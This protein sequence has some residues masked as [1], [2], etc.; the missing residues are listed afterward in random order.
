MPDDDPLPPVFIPMDLDTGT[1]EAER[2]GEF[3]AD[4]V[5][6]EN[7]EAQTRRV[8][9]TLT[10]REEQ[11]L[12]MR[13]GIAPKADSSGDEPSADFEITKQ[14]IREIEAK[15]LRKLRE[16]REARPAFTADDNDDDE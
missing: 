16:R 8:L 2:P 15:A 3:P 10:P 1:A 14:R 5:I 13:F 7:L 6:S 4:D 11:V 12:R 9:A